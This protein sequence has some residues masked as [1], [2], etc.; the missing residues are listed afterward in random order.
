MT[1]ATYLRGPRRISTSTSS[2]PA[3]SVVIAAAFLSIA[4]APFAA[5]QVEHSA[6]YAPALL[7]DAPSFSPVANDAS[8]ADPQPALIVASRYTKYVQTDEQVLQ[9]SSTDKIFLGIHDAVSSTAVMIW[10]A[11]AGYEQ[12][13]N[14]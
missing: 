2:L 3:L 8:G 9:L 7:P 12:V 4:S 5:A 6:A 1:D 11:V 13:L 14:D 10:V